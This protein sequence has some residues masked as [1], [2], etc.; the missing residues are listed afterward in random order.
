MQK[1][2]LGIASIALLLGGLIGYGIAKAQPQPVPEVTVQTSSSSSAHMM[3]DGTMMG[4]ETSSMADMMDDMSASLKGKTGDV[5]DEAFLTEMITHHEGAVVMAEVA[6]ASAKHEEIKNLAKDI[7]AAQNKEIG[8]MK[9]WL[10]E[11]YK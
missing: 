1:T 2:I 10:N 11:W 3:P 5:F 7:I 8:E 4:G 6:L 9:S